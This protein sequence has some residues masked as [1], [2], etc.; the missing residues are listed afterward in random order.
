MSLNELKTQVSDEDLNLIS[1]S[2]RLDPDEDSDL[3]TLLIKTAR[4]DIMGQV[5]EQI[6]DFYDHNETFN[7]AVLVEVSHLYENR[8][9]VSTQQT[10]E[11]PMVLYSLINSLK[12]SY[13]YEL[14]K[15]DEEGEENN[16]EG[17]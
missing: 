8:H 16:G 3:L 14:S 6:D 12:D 7:A 17:H 2:L 15:Q 5:G 4:A 11:V 1:E 10:Y 13:R 9:A